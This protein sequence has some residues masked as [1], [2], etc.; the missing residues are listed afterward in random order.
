MFGLRVYFESIVA[1]AA[2]P[3]DLARLRE[4]IREMMR[5]RMCILASV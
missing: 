4:A 1:G 3:A 2:A 5:D